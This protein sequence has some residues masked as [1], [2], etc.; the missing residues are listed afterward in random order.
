[1]LLLDD[2][3]HHH[4]RIFE[5]N[6]LATPAAS[7]PARLNRS[8]D[9]DGYLHGP[10]VDLGSRRPRLWLPSEIKE[11]AKRTRRALALFVQSDCH[12]HR[13]GVR[14][15]RVQG[16]YSAPILGI[17]KAFAVPEDIRS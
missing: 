7:P 16:L 13:R 14:G 17:F 8:R 9:F 10:V 1:M 11:W 15:T 6:T 5:P 3:G 4:N 12:N 2:A